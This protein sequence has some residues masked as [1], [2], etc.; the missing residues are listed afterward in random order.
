[1]ADW[2]IIPH[3]NSWQAYVSL[4]RYIAAKWYTYKTAEVANV[5]GMTSLSPIHRRFESDKRG[6]AHII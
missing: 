4:Q 5:S 3:T 2:C 6:S 1:L